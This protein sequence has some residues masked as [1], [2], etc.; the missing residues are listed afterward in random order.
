MTQC[1]YPD[2]NEEADYKTGGDLNLCHEHYNLWVFICRVL[3]ERR[4]EVDP[5]YSRFKKTPKE[6]H[7]KDSGRVED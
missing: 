1:K 5:W 6:A 4:V 7:V 2:C 3:F